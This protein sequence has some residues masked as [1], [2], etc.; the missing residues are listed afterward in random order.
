MT[1]H[2]QNRSQRRLPFN[3]QSVFNPATAHKKGHYDEDTDDG[4]ADIKDIPLF[5]E[6]TSN[7]KKSLFGR[8][9]PIPEPPDFSKRPS[10]RGSLA[11][12]GEVATFTAITS[13]DVPSTPP[14]HSE[15]L[16]TLRSTSPEAPGRTTRQERREVSF[17]ESP[18]SSREIQDAIPIPVRSR[19]A[20]AGDLSLHKS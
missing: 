4:S 10:R 3:L 18:R 8:G 14:R 15:D 19:Y 12:G 7:A 2:H 11:S 1:T 6:R 13:D 16:S 17:F 5:R 20:C 9:S